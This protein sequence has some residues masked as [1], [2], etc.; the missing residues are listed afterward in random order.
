MSKMKTK[1]QIKQEIGYDDVYTLEEFIHE[2][3][4]GYIKELIR[5]DIQCAK[6]P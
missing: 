3:D 2:V 6:E 1:K 4:E 5:K